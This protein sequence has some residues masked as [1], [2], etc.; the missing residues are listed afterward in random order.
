MLYELI[1]GKVSYS[2]L[3]PAEFKVMMCFSDSAIIMARIERGRQIDYKI[4]TLYI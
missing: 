3:Y 1:A 2:E 4:E